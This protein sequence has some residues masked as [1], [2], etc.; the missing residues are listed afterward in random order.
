MRCSGGTAQAPLCHSESKSLSSFIF[1]PGLLKK[2]VR[3]C[4]LD[5]HRMDALLATDCL[6]V[7][8]TG[9]ICLAT[10]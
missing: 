4:I 1:I 2:L 6:R 8:I 7:L 10:F 5:C 9:G 3:I